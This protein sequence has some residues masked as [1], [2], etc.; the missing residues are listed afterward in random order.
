MLDSVRDS[1]NN[2]PTDSGADELDMESSGYL[3]DQ[4][5]NERT[6]DLGFFHADFEDF[7][8]RDNWLRRVLDDLP[9]ELNK[10]KNGKQVFPSK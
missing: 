3:L 9:F 5:L 7:L 6:H 8:V 10:T 4:S 2:N 1:Y